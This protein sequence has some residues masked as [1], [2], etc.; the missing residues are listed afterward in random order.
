MTEIQ[1]DQIIKALNGIQW[2]LSIIG[3]VSVGRFVVSVLR[4]HR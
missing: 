1:A 3:G 2:A 4:S